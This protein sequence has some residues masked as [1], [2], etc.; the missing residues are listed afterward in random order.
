[1]LKCSVG[2]GVI[3]ILLLLPSGAKAIDVATPVQYTA[4]L[5]AV[6]FASIQ[7]LDISD[8]SV[9]ISNFE[10]AFKD[11]APRKDDDSDLLNYVLHPL[12]GSETYLRARE[13]DFG[14]IGSFAFSMGA[15][16]TWEY[17][18]ESWIE[19]PSSQDL[20]A[21]TGIGWFI[22][23]LRYQIKQSNEESGRSSFWVD[24]IWTT[25]EYL[26]FSITRNEGELTSTISLN[27]PL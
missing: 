27:F 2:R 11:P 3:I 21:T 10:R 16:I 17:I 5:M 22:G 15:S 20:L 24:P 18:V 9:S 25:L 26:D 1:M 6:E 12:M 19:H 13:G 23:E 7:V 8:N 14:V 4:L